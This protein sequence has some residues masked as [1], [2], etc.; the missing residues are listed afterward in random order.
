MLNLVGCLLITSIIVAQWLKE[1]GLDS[2]IDTL[3]QQLVAARD[4]YDTEKGR[5]TALE[6]DVAQLK[7]SVE[8]TVK[9]RKEAEDNLA[10]MVAERDAQ[11]AAAANNVAAVNETIESQGKQW[12]E[13]LAE[14]DAKIKELSASLTATRSRLDE[15]VSK[16]KEAAAR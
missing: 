16:L 8:S 3:N 13:A 14:R 9:A 15:A 10:K 11:N 2:R 7:E 1:Q 4:Q 6:G 12:K 5:A